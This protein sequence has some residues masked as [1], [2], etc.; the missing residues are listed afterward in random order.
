[1]QRSNRKSREQTEE[2]LGRT[3][4]TDLPGGNGRP[5][6]RFDDR[7][8]KNPRIA[9][10][11]PYTGG[12]L[13]DAAIQDAVVVNLRCRLPGVQFSGITLNCQNFIE[14]HG[15]AAFPLVGAG[16]PFFQM[17]I[18]W[19]PPG[20]GLNDRSVRYRRVRNAL[21]H[22]P[23]ARRIKQYLNK[24]KNRLRTIQTEIRH[25]VEGYRFLRS[26]DLLLYSGGGQL[27]D[28]YGGPWGLP[29]SLC[30]WALLARL[31]GVPCA[32][33]SVG[34]GIINSGTSRKL[35]SIALRLCCYRSFR[36]MRS[37]AAAGFLFYRA[38][39]DDVVPDL[40]LSLPDSELP[41]SAR[42]IR[43]MAGG[44]PVVALSPMAFA[45]PV[46]WPAPDRA[47]HDRYLRET[48]RVLAGLCERGYFVVIACSSR[49]DDESVIPDIVEHLD[50]DTKAKLHSQI[51]F[52]KIEAW[53][54][55]IS[56]LR[57]SDYLIASRLHGAI[58]G[59]ITQTPVI[60]ISFASKVDWVLEYLHQSD[61]R[62]DIRDFTAEDVLK[63]LDR[64]QGSRAAVVKQ[65]ES[66]RGGILSN[67]SFTQQYD[68]L[69]GL[70]LDHCQSRI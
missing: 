44:R 54:E 15:T 30:K 26:H 12:N 62:L 14:Q 70:A 7:F 9:L 66:C 20:E 28:N 43:T 50:D 59:F 10:L 13:G 21:R 24:G 37:R 52:P 18:K 8:P 68:L 63:V 40:A 38:S 45:K 67:S 22:L 16:I 60:A 29:F 55:L 34:V 48:A 4:A 58:F 41:Q 53:R 35:I 31:A 69:A 65:I 64:I 6:R 2:S 36:E 25:W 47:L 49:G 3:R 39:N 61:Y 46:N 33:A 56:V 11:T 57:A 27:D 23:G 5:V 1:M 19:T 42:F 51:H 17:E 32:M